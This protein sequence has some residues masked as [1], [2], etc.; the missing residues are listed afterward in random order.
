MKK[1]FPSILKS[2]DDHLKTKIYCFIAHM[3]QLNKVFTK[4]LVKISAKEIKQSLLS[5]A[6]VYHIRL[7]A[8]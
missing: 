7:N 4:N 1:S 3:L 8:C 2:N 5:L 6:K